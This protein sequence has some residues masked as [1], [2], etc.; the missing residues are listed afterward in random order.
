MNEVVPPVE[1]IEQEKHQGEG[2][3]DE[4]NFNKTP[5]KGDEGHAFTEYLE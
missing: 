2:R 4:E 5:S 1:P 3:S